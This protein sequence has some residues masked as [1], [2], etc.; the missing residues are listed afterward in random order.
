MEEKQEKMAGNYSF[1][2]FSIAHTYNLC[3]NIPVC[4][5]EYAHNV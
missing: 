1:F 5:N 4:V 2:N 3:Y